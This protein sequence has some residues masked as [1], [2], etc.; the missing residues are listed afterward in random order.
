MDIE[1]RRADHRVTVVI[2][3]D[4]DLYGGV[5]LRD[6]ILSSLAEHVL[7][8]VIDVTDMQYI[9]SSGIALLTDLRNLMRERDGFFALLN[10][11]GM[12]QG[13]LQR[14]ALPELFKIYMLEDELP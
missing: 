13:S 5:R 14:A 3:G 12:L 1:I 9:D 4:V 2:T 11:S 10:R 6:Q 7:S 8:L